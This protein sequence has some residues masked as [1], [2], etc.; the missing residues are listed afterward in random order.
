MCWCWNRC[1]VKRARSECA[2]ATTPPFPPP[3]PPLLLML[4]L[5]DTRPGAEMQSGFPFP[6]PTRALADLAPR[7]NTRAD[8][9]DD[10][11]GDCGGCAV[12]RLEIESAGALLRW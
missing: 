9:A 1:P 7:F 12:Q 8:D 6:R 10:D 3:P 5:E 11:A 4:L 2:A